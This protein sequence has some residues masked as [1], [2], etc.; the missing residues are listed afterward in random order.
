MKRSSP[1]PFARLLALILITS[2]L[3]QV[4]TFA[5][6]KLIDRQGTIRKLGNAGFVIVPDKQRTR[7]APSNLAEEFRKD[8]LRV[9][10]SGEVGTIPPNVRLIGTPL[11]L[12]A[13]SLATAEPTPGVRE[14]RGLKPTAQPNKRGRANEPT[15]I[16]DKAG[17]VESFTDKSSQD[18]ALKQI[19]FN[20]EILLI[21]RWAGSGQDRIAATSKKTGESIQVV[22]GYTRGLTRDLRRHLKIYAVAK[23]AKWKVETKG[24]SRPGRPLPQPRGA[25]AAGAANP[26]GPAAADRAP[27]RAR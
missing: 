5:G 3:W 11:K 9:V 14:L 23:D 18:A 19:N 17:L 1:I 26:A 24:F 7:Y 10:F 4:N 6:E 20:K 12:T 15:V 21:F 2:C 25:P 16:K 13:I 27:I 8:Q 22:F